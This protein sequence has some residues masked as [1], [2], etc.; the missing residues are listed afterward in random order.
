[1]TIFKIL[2]NENLYVYFLFVTIFLRS[3][4][5]PILTF[6]YI[7]YIRNRKNEKNVQFRKLFQIIF[8]FLLIFFFIFHF[9][10][11]REKMI[12]DTKRSGFFFHVLLNKGL[13]ILLI[14]LI[15]FIWIE[16]Y[17]FLENY[18]KKFNIFWRK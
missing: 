6:V 18:T 14:Y 7:Y 11:K 9:F 13:F 16:R 4:V 15:F 2:K 5:N 17:K 12:I 10:F 1:M 3:L 8:L